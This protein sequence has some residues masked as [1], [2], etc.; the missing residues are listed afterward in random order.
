MRPIASKP[1]KYLV[2]SFYSCTSWLRYAYF[3]KMVYKLN[4]E[5]IIKAY[6]DTYKA[7]L[8]ALNVEL[9]YARKQ[10]RTDW[11]NRRFIDLKSYLEDPEV[12]SVA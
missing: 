8:E 7:H 12:T 4:S 2:V 6:P 10:G 9:A 11:I 3:R 5:M 1:E